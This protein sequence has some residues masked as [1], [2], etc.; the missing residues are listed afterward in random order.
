MPLSVRLDPGTEARVKRLA[1]RTGQSKSQ[2]VREA[3]A[4]YA[5]DREQSVPAQSAYERLKHVI[6][7]ARGG[8]DRLSE[9]T[10]A[11]FAAL[12]RAKRHAGRPR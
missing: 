1:F 12:V 5:G 8:A 3:I 4:V 10:G 9:D 2:V 7:V 6:G 11:A